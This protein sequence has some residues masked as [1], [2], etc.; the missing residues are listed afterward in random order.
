[1]MAE[2][3]DL[4]TEHFDPSNLEFT[5]V[6][7]GNRATNIIPGQA[8]AR[9]NIRFNDR[10]SQASLKQWIET[11]CVQAA[12]GDVTCEVQYAQG[13]SDAFLTRPGAF[14]DLVSQAVAEVTGKRPALSTSGGT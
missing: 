14:V 5:S 3:L 11:R 9:F 13:N 12:R 4:G 1:L 10:H 6:D 2:T 8:R 7:V